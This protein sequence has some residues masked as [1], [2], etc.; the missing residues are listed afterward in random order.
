MAERITEHDEFLLSRLVDGD[1]P[2]EEAAALRARL[3]R[4]PEM[5]AAYEAYR[6]IDEALASRRAD[7]AEVDFDAFRA[8]V[9]QA[10]EAVADVAG[11]HGGRI[12]KFP[13]WLKVGLPLAA[14][15]AIAL[16]VTLRD[17]SWTSD[18]AGQRGSPIASDDDDQ[19]T[20][21][22][23][24]RVT[25]REGDTES[26]APSISVDVASAEDGGKGSI[27][28]QFSRPSGVISTERNVVHVGYQRSDA[29]ARQ[30]KQDDDEEKNRLSVTQVVPVAEKPKVIMIDQDF[31]AL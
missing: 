2:A 21:R 20:G 3:E 12:L 22:S 10:V 19:N 31:S 4:E 28:V 1:L 24:A 14:A 7:R 25:E 18:D 11:V 23:I 6:K 5:K 30:M 13:G 16:V 8:Q 9:M 27:M 26:E 15:A 17:G 29:L